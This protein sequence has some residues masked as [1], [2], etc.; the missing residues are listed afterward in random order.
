V[1]EVGGWGKDLW[2][3]HTSSTAAR[4]CAD[5]TVA[6]NVGS[7]RRSQAVRVVALAQELVRGDTA[8]WPSLPFLQ[9]RLREE[10][11]FARRLHRGVLYGDAQW[12][13]EPTLGRLPAMV[14]A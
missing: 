3:H 7:G 5:R 1:S 12:G 14:S 13:V 2:P 11:A 8:V 4:R 9:Q 10:V 6:L